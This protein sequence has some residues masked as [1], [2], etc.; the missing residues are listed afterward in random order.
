MKTV[1]GWVNMIKSDEIRTEGFEDYSYD[2]TTSKSDNKIKLIKK[3]II[4]VN[5]NF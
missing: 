2:E 3:N 1:K 5:A 4:N